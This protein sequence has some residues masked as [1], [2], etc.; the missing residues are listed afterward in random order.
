MSAHRT[1]LAGQDTLLAC[2]RA[3]AR[4]PFGPRTLVHARHAVAAL[5]PDFAHFNNAIHR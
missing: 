2:W 4:T 3:L 1:T 5:S